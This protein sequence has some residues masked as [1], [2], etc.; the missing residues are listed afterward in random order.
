MWP[1]WWCYL[2]RRSFIGVISNLN[3]IRSLILVIWIVLLTFSK[4]FGYFCS[5]FVFLGFF[6]NKKL[7]KFV[8]YKETRTE[9]HQQRQWCFSS[10][11]FANLGQIYPLDT[12]KLQVH[13][14]FRGRPERLIYVQF[15]SCSQ[16]VAW[17]KALHYIN[18]ARIMIFTDLCSPV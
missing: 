10:T 18:F 16:Q 13:K 1:D 12:G 17:I 14:T 15:T 9:Q 2:L 8:N 7:V 5:V 3:D 11:F 6:A 4:C